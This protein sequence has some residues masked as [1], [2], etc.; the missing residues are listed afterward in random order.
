MLLPFNW[1]L[2]TLD[3]ARQLVDYI[4]KSTATN[5]QSRN[6]D[7][8]TK[9]GVMDI[10]SKLREFVEAADHYEANIRYLNTDDFERRRD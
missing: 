3:E 6:Y 9:V 2:L 10:Y 7:K 1:S 4:E 8:M 5:G